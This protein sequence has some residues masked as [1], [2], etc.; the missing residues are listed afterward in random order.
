MGHFEEALHDL[1]NQR[2]WIMFYLIIL[3][4]FLWASFLLYTGEFIW[5]SYT[6]AIIA[7]FIG[8][9]TFFLAKQIRTWILFYLIA[10]VA[11]LWASFLVAQG[12]FLWVSAFL[13]ITTVGVGF[14]AYFLC[15]HYQ[16]DGKRAESA[17]DVKQVT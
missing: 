7:G 6:L 11:I 15:D 1:P 12:A 4:A 13:V 2:T 8:I 3:V 10:F 9:F 5:L 17:K 16:N 14:F